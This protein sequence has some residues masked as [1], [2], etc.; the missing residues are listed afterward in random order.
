M[1]KIRRY[2]VQEAVNTDSSGVWTTG[3][4]T[5][6][7]SS[8]I[9]TIH[10]TDGLD[11]SDY[12]TVGITIDQPIHIQFTTTT[13]DT[14]A[15]AKDLKIETGT[16]FIK[17]PQGLVDKDSEKIYLQMIRASSSDATAKIVLI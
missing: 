15:T 2:T 3:T 16:H 6:V 14:V 8:V 9:D 5:T 17:I 10:G 1:A 13:T 7:S 12:H 4:A 11:I